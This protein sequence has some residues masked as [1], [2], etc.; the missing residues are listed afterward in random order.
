[1]IDIETVIYILLVVFLAVGLIYYYKSP[2]GSQSSFDSLPYTSYENTVTVNPPQRESMLAL[3]QALATFITTYKTIPGY[4]PQ[5]MEILVTLAD[6]IRDIPPTVYAYNSF[7]N[8]IMD[9][10]PMWFEDGSLPI[11]DSIRTNLFRIKHAITM[12]GYSLNLA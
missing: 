8:S 6:D 9:F 10:N 1:M 2:S 12:L 7:Y 5:K 3:Y 4:D 11:D